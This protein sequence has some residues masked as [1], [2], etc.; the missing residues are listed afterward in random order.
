MET[1]KH[2]ALFSHLL[3]MFGDSHSH[4]ISKAIA[5]AAT[6]A[7][8]KG[9]QPTLEATVDTMFELINNDDEDS[10]SNPAMDVQEVA[11]KDQIDEE[12]AIGGCTSDESSTYTGTIPKK[13][14]ASLAATAPE[15]QPATKL[16]QEKSVEELWPENYKKVLHQISEGYKV[17][18]LM[19]GLPGSGKSFLAQS[20]VKHFKFDARNHIF[21]ADDFFYDVNGRY[22][23]DVNRLSEAHEFTQNRTLKRMREGWS[24]VI[25]DNTSMKQWEMY[26]YIK[27]AVKHHYLI[28]ILEP[29]TP[30][31]R[32]PWEL[33]NRNKHKVPRDKIN[34][35]MDK[36]EK[37]TVRRLLCNLDFESHIGLEPA[38]RHF[39]PFS[40]EFISSHRHLFPELESEE[41]LAYSEQKLIRFTAPPKPRR[42]CFENKPTSSWEPSKSEPSSSSMA[43]MNWKAYEED[44]FWSKYD[45]HG[46]EP[47]QGNTEK[48]LNAT[49]SVTAPPKP[50]REISLLRSLQEA[51]R[52]VQLVPEEKDKAVDDN[53]DTETGIVVLDKHKKNCVNENTTFKEIRKM[54]PTVG[55]T[56][57]WDLFLKCRGDGDW[58]IDIL[59]NDE[60]TLSN[61]M[62]GTDDLEC[63]C[64]GKNTT[65]KIQLFKVL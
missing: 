1:E 25:I 18:V 50:K 48:N 45:K 51:A 4:I 36:Y 27:F 12:G 9:Q 35:M 3:E 42:N 49:Q 5:K 40:Q 26:P 6:A 24:P 58:T 21:S 41:P 10:H 14:F 64:D 46:D 65:G 44:N 13:S 7:S 63:G 32:T 17:L 60:A 31:A 15:F 22:V 39:P 11:I 29:V 47:K 53:W 20:I 52:E 38:L 28:E 30:W 33:A 19:R 43:A 59:V 16:S 62:G 55:V 61:I 57:L 8:D 2:D 54:F 56:Y 37:T 34:L 23:Y